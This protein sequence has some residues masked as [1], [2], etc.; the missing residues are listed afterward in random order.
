MKIRVV[1]TDL[2]IVS[3][4]KPEGAAAIDYERYNL[5]IDDHKVLLQRFYD[6]GIDVSK[7]S[8]MLIMD[9]VV[10]DRPEWMPKNS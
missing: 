7:I 5:A 2:E 6:A 4:D 1:Y 3:V 8:E 10:I 9:G